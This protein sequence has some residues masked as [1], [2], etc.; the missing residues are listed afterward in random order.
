MSERLQFEIH[1]DA[2]QISAFVEHALPAHE[3]ERMLSHLAVCPECRAVVAF[4]LPN[5][6]EPAKSM[7]TPARKPWW[8]QWRFAWPAAAALAAIV[9]LL[10]YFYKGAN[11][12]IASESSETAR[13]NPPRPPISPLQ[14]AAPSAAPAV[15]G[16]RAG[17]S[18]N[19]AAVAADEKHQMV[20]SS[21]SVAMLPMAGRNI[22]SSAAQ[23]AAAAPAS[24]DQRA[25]TG[26]GVARGLGT[27]V[28][29]GIAKAPS[30]VADAGLQQP[31]SASPATEAIASARPAESASAIAPAASSAVTVEV[32][33]AALMPT[34][35]SDAANIAIDGNEVG[36]ALLKHAL[37][38]HQPV[39]SM[40][41]QA[42]RMV[43]I[44][45]RNAVFLSKDGGKHW[46]AV[47]VRWPSRAV[48][49]NLVVYPVANPARSLRDKAA[50]LTA[51]PA[52]NGM[53][54]GDSSG[55]LG[56]QTQSLKEAP[57]SSLSGTVTDPSGAVIPGTSVSVTE[58]ATGM[59][60]AAKT[61]DRGRYHV[62]GLA[63]GT[64]RV[65]AQAPGFNRQ[66]LA[67]VSVSVSHP[68]VQ[69][70][71]LTVGAV[72]QAVMVQAGSSEISE[73]AK[74]EKSGAARSASPVFEITTDRGEHWT[75]AD[76]VNWTHN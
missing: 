18:G 12:P 20:V 50:S 63:P 74:K 38:S 75:S 17:S 3:R 71:S 36:G 6:E 2:D 46:K 59:V 25:V 7:P 51:M 70:I 69:D 31:V 55:A 8:A 40:A 47:P 30:A 15:Q 22:A 73:L 27:G 48:K 62:D 65:E 19:G 37:P 61:D 49:A 14:P 56:A 24:A 76:G 64:Y 28:G 53:S 54:A 45:T 23:P 66:V 39:L 32:T 42:N 68:A 57:D 44:D 58:A 16:P 4:S 60:R 67:A 52:G 33:N 29:S 43:A 10:L 21:R 35:S 72:S 11:A 5:I 1:P 34:A 9:F 41:T 13:A 26:A